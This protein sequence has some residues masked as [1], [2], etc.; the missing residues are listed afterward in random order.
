[1]RFL[2]AQLEAFLEGGLWLDLAAHANNLARRLGEGLSAIPGA[3]LLHPVETNQVF[4]R[5]PEAVI[6]GLLAEGFGLY[7][8]PTPEDAAVRLVCGFERSVEEVEA[9]LA[10]ARCLAAA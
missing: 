2:S 6:A 7:R 9:F 1:M 8:W 3:E 5:L 10:A 4:C